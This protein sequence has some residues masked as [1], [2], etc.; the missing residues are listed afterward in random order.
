[1]IR[2]IICLIT[3]LVASTSLCMSQELDE[4]S[5]PMF[6]GGESFE[7]IFNYVFQNSEE[8]NED[9]FWCLNTREFKYPDELGS[10]ATR[11]LFP[12]GLSRDLRVSRLIRL[13]NRYTYSDDDA[14][15]GI[16]IMYKSARK[17][18][19]KQFGQHEHS[20]LGAEYWIVEESGSVYLITLELT[21]GVRYPE[22]EFGTYVS[23]NLYQLNSF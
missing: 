2:R 21:N 15:Y 11:T 13:V 9:M 22:A 10:L 8:F 12:Y 19:D 5:I 1:M 3:L 23:L 4:V 6:V 20:S 17:S 16:D 7:S 14:F 18:L